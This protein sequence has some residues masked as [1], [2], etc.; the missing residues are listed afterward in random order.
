MKY[1]KNCTVCGSSKTDV[2]VEIASLPV[3]CNVLLSSKEDAASALTG[4]MA[5]GFCSSCGHIFNSTNMVDQ[6]DYTRDYENSLHFS[7][8]FQD[9][10]RGLATKLIERYELYGKVIV[11]IGCGKGD[12]L[13]LICE[14]GDNKGI[15]FDPTYHAV[16]D[17]N[18]ENGKITYITDYYSKKY[19]WAGGDMIICR[20]VLEHLDSPREFLKGL[21]ENIGERL[22]TKIYFEVPN[23]YYIL[24]E[25]SYWDII[26]EH[27][28]YFSKGSLK[29]LFN[30]TGFEILTISD[31]FD[32]QFLYI[33]AKPVEKAIDFKVPESILSKLKEEV[34]AFAYKY[35]LKIVS[36]NT[37]LKNIDAHKLRAVVWGSGSKGAAFLN[38][39][40]TRS[41]IDYVV[42]INPHKHGKYIPVTAQKIVNPEFLISYKP[43]LIIVMNS[44]Y[45]EEIWKAIK[46]M[47]LNVKVLTA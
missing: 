4:D 2:F 32:G 29:L 31:S 45:I 25:R 16:R 13:N 35:R 37:V 5:L 21:R 20:H 18:N 12:F 28:S 41:S 43:E 19:A 6:P 24:K 3:N 36:W 17:E 23:A 30:S 34:A 27:S 40:R 22:G 8:L 44:I 42:D 38:T 39:L 26:Y 46:E 10:A 15:G 14:L 33:E 9:Y 7:P 11:E 47:K 1:K